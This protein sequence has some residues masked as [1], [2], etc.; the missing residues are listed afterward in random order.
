MDDIQRIQNNNCPNPSDDQDIEA[1]YTKV[2][3]TSSEKDEGKDVEYVVE[4]GSCFEPHSPTNAPVI[5]SWLDLTVETK[6]K[7]KVP[8]KAIINKVSGSITGGL[9]GI[10]GSSGSGKTTLLS[11]LSLRLDRNRMNC[12]GDVRLNGRAYNKNLL[13]SMSGYVMQDDLVQAMLTV[14]ETLRYT[15]S[16]RM[17]KT[18]TRAE[19]EARVEEVMKLMG[20][21]YCR[22]VIVG[23]SRNKGIS[24]G[25]RKRLCVAMELLTKPQLLFLDEPTS[26]LDSTTALDLME[27]LKELADSGE[28]TVVCTIHQPQTKIFN[29]LDN[30]LLMKKGSIVY[31]GNREQV[32]DYFAKQGYPCPELMNP[33]DHVL[34]LVSLGTKMHKEQAIIKNIA[35]PVD[36]ESGLDKA[37]FN[38]KLTQNWLFQFLVLSHRCFRERFRRWDTILMNIIVTCVVGTFIGEGAWNN[39]GNSQ[40]AVSKVNPILFFCVIHQGVLSSLQGT[41]AFPAE[42]ALMLRERQAG[43]YYVSAYFFSKSTVDMLIQLINPIIFSAFVYPMCGLDLTV[44]KYFTFMAFNMLLSVCATSLANMMCCLFVSVEMSTVTLVCAMEITR[45]YSA[46]FVSPRALENYP[47][48]KLFDAISYMKYGYVGLCLNTYTNWET[49]CTKKQQ[50]PNGTCPLNGNSAIVLYGYDQYT[51]QFCAGIMVVYIVV[52][53]L[54]AYLSL[55]FI[56]V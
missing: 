4:K 22:D 27:I 6:P 26:G 42:R 34:D 40:A 41:Y 31:Q 24:G 11:V 17:S 21:E 1:T 25:E 12:T 7:G 46:F 30:L 35:V 8:V 33:A 56:K 47:D 45:L 36:L 28:C 50:L 23:D 5:L 43:T 53:R 55:R 18:F 29:M 38:K 39:I 20:I 37:E 32:I 48:W 54:I 51:I 19:R 3:T 14:N 49:T 44:N 16:L 9:W 13:K 52:C 15:A 10:M 2:V